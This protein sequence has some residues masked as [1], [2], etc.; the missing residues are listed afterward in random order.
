VPREDEEAVADTLMPVLRERWTGASLELQRRRM[1][2]GASLTAGA[3]TVT[4][5]R[6]VV[7]LEGR[8]TPTFTLSHPKSELFEGRLAASFSSARAHDFSVSLQDGVRV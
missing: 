2:Y 5:D 6:R 1:R 3:R 4:L 8:D 7:G